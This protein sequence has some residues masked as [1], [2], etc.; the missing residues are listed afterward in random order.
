MNL[1]L[2]VW[3]SIEMFYRRLISSLA[4]GLIFILSLFVMPKWTF[5]VLLIIFCT[6]GTYEFF[7]LIERKGISTLKLLGTFIAAAIPITIFTEFEL[8]KGWELFFI[9][10]AIFIL[11]VIQFTRKN[12]AQAIVSISLTLF[13]IFYVSWLLSFIMRIFL[14]T[15]GAS[16]VFFL[17][18]VTKMGDVGAYIGGTYFGKH[19]LISRISPRK[20]IEGT[21]SAFLTTLLFSCLSIIYLPQISLKHLFLLGL[22]LGALAQ[23]GDLSESLIKRDYK[24]KD[25]GVL[26]P[27]FGGV[28]DLV[29]SIL[30]TAPAFYF[31]LIN[32]KII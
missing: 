1:V 26:I 7:S 25:S 4:L 30:F 9:V 5:A 11:F 28:L 2:N 22:L 16:L 17:V 15:H 19:S 8:T 21:V 32:V 29:D 13:G 14:L 31:Y 27:G 18:L 10:L 20:T 23:I 24:I 6:L 3:G 12:N